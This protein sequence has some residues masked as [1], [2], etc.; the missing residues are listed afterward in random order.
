[1]CNGSGLKKIRFFK[2]NCKFYVLFWNF[3]INKISK[4]VREQKN[5]NRNSHCRNFRQCEF[6]NQITTVERRQA[7]RLPASACA[8]DRTALRVICL[9]VTTRNARRL[10]CEQAPQ[11]VIRRAV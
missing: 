8:D 9:P 4:E 6:K 2:I 3:D 11:R 1:M 7:I 5:T 10:K